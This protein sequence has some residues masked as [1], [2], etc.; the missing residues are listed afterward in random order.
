M[1]KFNTVIM[2]LFLFILFGSLSGCATLDAKILEM[3]VAQIPWADDKPLMLDTA[4]LPDKGI[5]LGPL[6]YDEMLIALRDI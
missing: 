1:N 5:M 2:G 3:K 4:I 6:Q